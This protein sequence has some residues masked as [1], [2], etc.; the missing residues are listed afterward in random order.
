MSRYSN[1]KKAINENDLYRNSLENRGV[2]KVIQYKTPTMSYP[3]VEETRR[4]TTVTHVWAHGDR[5]W[6]LANQYYADPNMW[7]VIAHYNKKPTE[8]HVEIGTEINI[9]QPLSRILKLLR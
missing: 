4:I 1:R 5:F 7:W 8:A 6:K 9:P 2:K 3:S